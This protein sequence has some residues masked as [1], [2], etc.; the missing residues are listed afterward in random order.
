MPL[1]DLTRLDYLKIDAEGAESAILQ[2]GAAV[3]ARFRPIVQ[4]ETTKN[5]TK[6]PDGYRR[7]RA[8]DSPNDVFI[9]K[10]SDEAISQAVALQ[11]NEINQQSSK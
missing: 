11:W 4:V 3:L 10:E 9:P 1:E 2:G 6:L 7:F 5:E 8:P